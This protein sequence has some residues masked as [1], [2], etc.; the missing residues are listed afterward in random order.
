M[1]PRRFDVMRDTRGC[2]SVQRVGDTHVS[3]R[4]F[5][6]VGRVNVPRRI[7]RAGRSC[8]RTTTTVYGLALAARD[9]AVRFG[10]WA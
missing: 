6:P 2:A 4:G 1:S 7:A 3:G 8:T 5:V 10:G 9:D